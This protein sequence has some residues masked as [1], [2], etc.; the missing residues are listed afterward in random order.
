MLRRG[1]REVRMDEHGHAAFHYI[2]FFADIRGQEHPHKQSGLRVDARP[3]AA[4]V[5]ARASVQVD[6]VAVIS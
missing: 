5:T 3:G 6:V 1:H 4:R 2:M